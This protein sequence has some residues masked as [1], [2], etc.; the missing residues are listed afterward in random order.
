MTKNKRKSSI[1]FTP[2][3]PALI[4]FYMALSLLAY[5][6][7]EIYVPFAA[8]SILTAIFFALVIFGALQLLYKD[9][10]R[11]AFIAGG[12]VF[13]FFSYGHLQILFKVGAP[14]TYI[15]IAAFIFLPVL[16]YWMRVNLRGLTLISNI[17]WLA[18]ISMT[19]YTTVDYQLRANSILNSNPPAAPVFDVSKLNK[20]DLPDIYYIILDSYARADTLQAIYGYD[21]SP[22]LNEMESVG[23]YDA[24]CSQSNFNSTELS[25]SSSLNMDY[26]QKLQPSLTP[27]TQT[28]LPL[29]AMIQNS[30]VHNVLEKSGYET[31]AFATGFPWSEW[32][33]ADQYI[34]PDVQSNQLNEFEVLFLDTTF[35]QA[36]QSAGW[37]NYREQEYQRY[38][39]RTRLVFEKLPELAKREGPQFYFVHILDPHPPFVFNADG[40]ET[41]VSLYTNATGT[42]ATEVY[43]KGYV[44]EVEFINGELS[45]L[46]RSLI[47]N[48]ERQP[49]IV[50][51]GDHGA[52]FQ[53]PQYLTT[54]L[55]MYYLPDHRDKL[56]PDITPVNTFRLIF[57]EYL[58][59]DYPLLDD[60]AYDSDKSY[61]DF[62]SIPNNCK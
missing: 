1:L 16:G 44:N 36:V 14:L 3:Y 43:P 62:K 30:T 49:V 37:V 42:D 31:I 54:I 17:I 22:F 39:E 57:N 45:K 34:A 32:R 4:S 9:I 56:Y 20:D 55:N 58:G 19:L 38:R 60:V 24:K 23:L 21:N 61:Y 13:L 27:D 2:V 8:R 51:Q 29:W 35:M 6:L 5:N 15:W 18:M 7:G 47:E 10:H 33:G 26:L 48:S 53:P 52:W 46:V 50:I 25:L 41:G 40:T 11:S 59:A 12:I 28:K